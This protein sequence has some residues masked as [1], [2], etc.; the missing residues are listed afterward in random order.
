[1]NSE[2]IERL[3]RARR[4]LHLEAKNA[5]KAIHVDQFQADII[6]MYGEVKF[7]EEFGLQVDTTLRVNG[8]NG[9]DFK[10]QVGFKEIYIDVKTYV[11]AYNLLVRDIEVRHL[12]DVYVLAQFYPDSKTVDLVGWEYGNVMKNCPMRDFGYGMINHY[13]HRSE[14]KPISALHAMLRKQTQSEVKSGLLD[15]WT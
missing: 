12:A 3:G 7:A 15:K 14:L 4:N 13:K 1:M 11:K 2:E 5:G 9:I 8:D 10:V 6:G